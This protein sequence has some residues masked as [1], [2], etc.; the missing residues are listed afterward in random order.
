MAVTATFVTSDLILVMDNGIGAS[1]Q[2]LSQSRIYKNVKTD[3]ADEDVY[4]VAQALLALQSKTC[5]AVQR[6]NVVEMESV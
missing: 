5:N 6:R 2:A 4:A 1:G 3:A